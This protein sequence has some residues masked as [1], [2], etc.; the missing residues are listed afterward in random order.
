MARNVIPLRPDI[1]EDGKPLPP[2]VLRVL[3]YPKDLPQEEIAEARQMHA[4]LIEEH[5]PRLSALV[6]KVIHEKLPPIEQWVGVIF[7]T[8][9]DEEPDVFVDVGPREGAIEAARPWAAIC[10]GLQETPLPDRLDVCVEA[11]G[12]VLLLSLDPEPALPVT[13]KQAEMI[14]LPTELLFAKGDAFTSVREEPVEVGHLIAA[15]KEHRR[16]LDERGDEVLEEARRAMRTHELKDCAGV[17]LS[18]GEEAQAVATVT[19]DKAK[20]I[21]LHH[22]FLTRK[23]ER[24]ARTGKIADGREF[25][26][27]PVVIWAKGHVSV[28]SRDVA[29]G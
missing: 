12:V 16:L 5:E 18:L 17:L 19:R 6:A 8:P 14:N 22:P 11:K 10:K 15:I 27:L 21:T 4:K 1:A 28:Q 9:T 13:R 29:L 2:A 26:Q 23:L 25:C 24:P 3:S 7:S 20:K